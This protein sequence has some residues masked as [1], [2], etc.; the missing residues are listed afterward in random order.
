MV[1]KTVKVSNHLENN[2][3]QDICKYFVLSYVYDALKSLIFFERKCGLHKLQ[4]KLKQVKSE[5]SQQ[6]VSDP[7]LDSRQQ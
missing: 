2:N 7:K 5:L 1:E 3:A 6:G 4:P